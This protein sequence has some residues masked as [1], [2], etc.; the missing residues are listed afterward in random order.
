M[1]APAEANVLLAQAIRSLQAGQVGEAEQLCRLILEGSRKNHQA[2]AILGQITTARG[3]FDEAR[4]LLTRAVTLAPREIDYHVLLAELL[5]TSGRHRVA[6]ARY[7]RALRLKRDYPPALAGKANA[8]VRGG[9]WLKARA[10]L[11]P[12]VTRG[13]EDAGMATVYA[14]ICGHEGDNGR[15]VEIASRHLDD[16]I[17]AEA[18]RTLLFEIAAAHQ[19]AGHHDEAFAGFSAA[20]QASGGRWDPAA[21]RAYLDRIMAVFTR[22][23][24]E[25]L[26]EPGSEAR[27]SEVP[28]FIVGMMRC[29]STLLEQII[30]AHPACHGAGEILCLPD[31]VA[32]LALRIGSNLGYPECGRDLD[33]G[34]LDALAEAHLAEIAPL[35]PGAKRICD[36]HLLNHEHLGLVQGLFPRARV[37]HTRRDPLD[38]CVSCFCHRFP[39]GVPAFTQDLRHLGQ[40]YN[41]YLALMAHW[42]EALSLPLLE[43]D[44][45]A[46]VA[47][48][49]GVTRRIIDFLGLP[50][51]DRCL[52]FHQSRREV[53]TLSRDQVSKP[54]YRTAIGRARR[55]EKHLGPLREVLESGRRGHP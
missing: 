20:N 52:G 19:R 34:D 11:E 15:A 26:P 27:R 46:L 50:W 21:S 29:G 41:D 39:P 45:E 54:I 51:D 25:A 2:L 4:D 14:R 37:I 35:A 53:L 28:V 42:R 40:R 44:Y 18:R 8:Y 16:R 23:F 48:Q 33:E 55:Y 17:S 5:V 47:D 32:S 9:Q 31:L 10:V 24:L 36:K 3:R 38:T 43:V 1:T 30:D 12:L 22:P 49:E 7:D 13:S 6:L